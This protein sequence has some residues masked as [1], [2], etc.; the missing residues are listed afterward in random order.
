MGSIPTL[1][2]PVVYLESAFLSLSL[3]HGHC[4]DFVSGYSVFFFSS[5]FRINVSMRSDYSAAAINVCVVTTTMMISHHW[6]ARSR[7]LTAW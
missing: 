2:M 4:V 7:L 1:T 3:S 6:M 5:T